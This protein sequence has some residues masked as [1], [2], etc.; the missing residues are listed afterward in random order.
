M[1][2]LRVCMACRGYELER[3]WCSFCNGSGVVTVRDIVGDQSD[4]VVADVNG[5]RV[6][7]LGK[8]ADGV[9]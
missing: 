5:V 6:E 4:C 7:R 1:S 8:P 3:R 2:D 9:K